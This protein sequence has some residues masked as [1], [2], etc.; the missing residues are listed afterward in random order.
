MNSPRHNLPTRSQPTAGRPVDSA[1]G[2]LRQEVTIPIDGI[3]LAGELVIPA[4]AQGVV[5][6]A[7]GSGSSRLSPRTQFVAE[8][9]TAAGVGTL[10]FELLTPAE[11]RR[12]LRTGEWRFDI[13]LLTGRLQQ[14]TGWIRNQPAGRNLEVGYFGF[15]TGAAAALV[16][17]ARLGG[18]IHAVISCG[19]RPD[20]AGEALAR[21]TAATLLVVGEQDVGVLSLNRGAFEHLTCPKQLTIVPG[22]GHLLG[23]PGALERAAALST[24]WFCSHLQGLAGA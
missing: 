24:D 18:A 21:V 15:G 1:P 19:G 4:G 16:A 17:A 7:D 10:M 3:E 13:E 6:F 8:K 23:E 20:F 11:Q 2:A 12:D 14:A 22:A 5:L 9:F